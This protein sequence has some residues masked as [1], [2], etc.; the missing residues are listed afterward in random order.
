MNAPDQAPALPAPPE[1]PT[2]APPIAP[3][4]APT[5][6]PLGA[7]AEITRGTG[8]LL[9]DLGYDWLRE[10]RLTTGRRVDLIGVNRRGAFAIIEVKSSLADFRADGKWRGYLD[11]CDSFYFAV[12]AEF[13]AGVLPAEQGLIVADGF[14]AAI[15]RE[16]A[17]AQLHP[18]RRKALTLRFA[19]KAAR[20]LNLMQDEALGG[21]RKL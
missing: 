18:S 7:T 17:P 20:R 11:W 13:P 21:T 10:F 9:S 4:E 8:R 16:A 3:P 14:G 5:G 12:A 2:G 15:V 1:A 6:A 19:R